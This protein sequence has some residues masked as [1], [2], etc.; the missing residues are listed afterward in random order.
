MKLDGGKT[1]LAGDVRHLL[2]RFIYEHA[3]Q[4]QRAGGG[5]RPG[6]C[7]GH[8]P[9]RVR[10]KHQPAP[11][12]TG[13]VRTDEAFRHP[14]PADLDT[15]EGHLPGGQIRARCRHHRGTDQKGIDMAGQA[16]HVARAF[17]ARFRDHQ[18][19][20]RHPPGQPP[21]D[22][23]VDR[24]I[25]QIAVIDT[26]DARAQSQRPVQ[27]GLI[28]DFRHHVEAEPLGDLGT[29]AISIIIEDRENQED[30]IRP[31]EA[32]LEDLIGIDD[33]VLGQNRAI[34]AGADP[35]QVL[36]RA[37]EKAEVGDHRDGIGDAGKG[38]CRRLR[39][40]ILADG[41][42]RRRGG[43]VLENEAQPGPGQRRTQAAG[44]GGELRGQSLHRPAP[45]PHADL[46][47]LV[48]NDGF[49]HHGSSPHSG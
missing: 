28:M 31:E 14:V 15:A 7:Q 20:L 32:G 10:R 23:E 36:G 19:V 33:D 45:R 24:K 9:A 44:R 35:R 29:G 12:C 17:D 42:G 48:E 16:A 37:I 18:A 34:D 27:F 39:R 5:Q 11:A 21:G 22:P 4:R 13:G 1:E 47:A 46:V 38:V 40:E 6:L 2:D 49:K 43:L 26:D 25:P 30:R 8:A 41:S 3:D